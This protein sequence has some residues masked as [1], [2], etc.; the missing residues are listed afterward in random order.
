MRQIQKVASSSSDMRTVELGSW[1]KSSGMKANSITSTSKRTLKEF[2]QEPN[3]IISSDCES[4]DHVKIGVE[5]HQKGQY[6]KALWSFREAIKSQVLEYGGDHPVVAQTLA[7]IGAVYLRQGRLLLAEDALR[8]ALEK[9]V[10]ARVRCN[11]DEARDQIAITNVL[12]N[13]GNLAYLQGNYEKSMNFY[14]QNLRELYQRG[15]IDSQLAD[16]LHNI[17]RLHVIRQEWD[18]AFSV[19]EKCRAAE[20]EIYGSKSPQIA[21]TLE[22]IGY[23]HLS[24]QSYDNAIV[25]FSEALT[26]HKDHYGAI[27]E[28][29]ATGLTNVAMVLGAKGQTDAAIDT[30]EAA[31]AVFRSIPG[32][33]ENHRAYRVACRGVETLRATVP[34]SNGIDEQRQRDDFRS[35]QRKAQLDLEHRE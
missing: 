30:Y 26:I 33:A 24:K 10:Q 12:N 18:A 2:G 7:N 32:V 21:D 6:E 27:N 25:V 5:F 17:G 28:N 29:V 22:L 4:L 31:K 13:L 19:L 16:A 8:K 14:T 3:A 23:V 34:A 20:E 15:T 9:M 11:N 35:F 1:Q